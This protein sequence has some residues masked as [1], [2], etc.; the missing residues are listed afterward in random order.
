MN[1]E[2]P[3]RPFRAGRRPKDNLQ[4]AIHANELRGTRAL[5]RLMPVLAAADRLG[6]IRGEIVIAPAVNP[7]GLS[8]LV[9]NKHRGCDDLLGRDNFNRN[10]LDLSDA[11]AERV[12]AR[13]GA[14]A[15]GNV[16]WIRR[17]ASDAT[18]ERAAGV[19]HRKGLSGL[20]D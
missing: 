18:G 8:Q 15:A 1:D 11:G 2:T 3:A 4:A 13:L 20:G 5:H 12:G 10:W 6:R 9:G 17:A 16:A 19:T 14:D 7:I